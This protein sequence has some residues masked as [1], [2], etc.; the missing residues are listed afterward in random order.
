LSREAIVCD[1]RRHLD[2]E[3]A[4]LVILRYGLEDVT[5]YYKEDGMG[6]R[7]GGRGDGLSIKELAGIKGMKQDKVRRIIKTSLVKLKPHM[8]EWL[9]QV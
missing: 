3:R 8:G 7:R 9:E 4:E 2:T 1:L 6:S 5:R